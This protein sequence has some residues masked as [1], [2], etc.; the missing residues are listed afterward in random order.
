M[1]KII[2]VLG[3]IVLSMTLFINSTKLV[4]GSN[5]NL[6]TLISLDKANA[7]E[8]DKGIKKVRSDCSITLSGKAGVSGTWLG[9]SYTI[10]AAGSITLTVKDAQI[11][12]QINGLSINCVD[13]Y[14]I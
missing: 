1:K 12:C 10:P 13:K 14:C 5:L 2:G 8:N 4:N 9:I 3:V 6:A 11:D 7:E